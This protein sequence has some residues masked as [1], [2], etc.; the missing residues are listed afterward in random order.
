MTD[1]GEL[2]VS[3]AELD[4]ALV[5]E[6]LAPYL[7]L[8]KDA[9][10][11]RPGDGW[12]LLPADLRILLYLVARRAMMALGFDIPDDAARATDVVRD[13]GVKRGPAHPALRGLLQRGL[14]HQSRDRRYSVP[15][16]AIPKVRAMLR[17]RQEGSGENE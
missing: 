2:V 7:R 9:S 16:H 5:A 4:R 12:H 17:E 6:I 14:V 11:I 3:G 1:L 13:T 8:D 15:S 10:N